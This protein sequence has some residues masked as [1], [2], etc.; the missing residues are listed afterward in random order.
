MDASETVHEVLEAMTMTSP[1]GGGGAAAAMVTGVAARPAPDGAGR[2]DVVT[3]AAAPGARLAGA[4]PRS[5]R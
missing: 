5:P 1:L 2:L 3:E 4:G